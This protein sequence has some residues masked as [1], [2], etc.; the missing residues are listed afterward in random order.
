M[1][2]RSIVGLATV[3]ILERAGLAVGEAALVIGGRP[4]L[5]SRD[6]A[7]GSSTSGRARTPELRCCKDPGASLLDEFAGVVVE[8]R[9]AAEL[10]ENVWGLA[11]NNHNTV[12]LGP[13]VGQ[14]EGAGYKLRRRASPSPA[15]CPRSGDA[16][17]A[18]RGS[19]TS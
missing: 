9:P 4:A 13:L 2:E 5:R 3:E 19:T 6:R 18:G 12:P 17:E 7:T 15:G 16:S 8:A 10:M 11:Y 14:L 1:L